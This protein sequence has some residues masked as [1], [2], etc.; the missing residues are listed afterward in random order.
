M[1]TPAPGDRHKTPGFSWHPPAELAAWARQYAKEHDMRLSALLTLALA[2]YREACGRSPEV[3]STPR[4]VEST[5]APGVVTPQPQ[6]A[7]RQ[8]AA[9]KPEA[10]GCPH[11]YPDIKLNMGRRFCRIC[12][13]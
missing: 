5:T 3:Q 2:S 1:T 11:T 7:A 6:P 9:A 13:K 4:R 8:P 10:A 12:D